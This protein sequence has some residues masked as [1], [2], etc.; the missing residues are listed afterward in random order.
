MG[1][2]GVHVKEGILTFDPFMLREDEFLPEKRR[3]FYVNVL[4]T[5]CS[6]DLKKDSLGFTYCQVPIIY[7]I[8]KTSKIEV[9]FSEGRQYNIEGNQLDSTTSQMIFK[10]T[11]EILKL[12]IYLSRDQV[13]QAVLR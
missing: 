9:Y 2:L 3:Y 10:R 8:S 4:K 6:I 7:Q 11:N 13:N 5:R 1:E 12:I